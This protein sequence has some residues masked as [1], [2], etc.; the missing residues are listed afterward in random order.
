MSE[1]DLLKE[2]D[3]YYE[4]RIPYH[5]IYMSYTDNISMEKLLAPVIE[6]IEYNIIGKD[7]LE[8][9]CGTGNWI[10]VLSKRARSVVAT[11][12]S[13]GYLIEARQKEYEHEN[14]VFKIADAYVLEGIQGNFNVAF[15]SDWWSHMPKS[16]IKGFLEILHDKLLPG[17]KVVII[18]LLRTK[19]LDK[20]FSH[21]DEEGNVIQKRTL[22][23]GREYRVVKNFPTEDELF[24]YVKPY[25]VHVDYYEDQKL[26]RWILS[27]TLK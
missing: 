25:A 10:Q 19:E 5:D 16:R 20:M 24:A 14:V 6:R 9:A 22:P 23:N 4:D 21:I 15:G 27:Y 8:I 26:K 17:S 3:E 18:D 12:L 13:E 7:V 11:D 1:S 2:M